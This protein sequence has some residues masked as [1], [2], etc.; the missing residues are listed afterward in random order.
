MIYNVMYARNELKQRKPFKNTCKM[1]RFIPIVHYSGVNAFLK[2]HSYLYTYMF[3]V[4]LDASLLNK[5]G[6]E[7][8]VDLVICRVIFVVIF[9]ITALLFVAL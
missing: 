5:Q 9:G 3:I 2:S 4:T 7:V 8:F 6:L 1:A